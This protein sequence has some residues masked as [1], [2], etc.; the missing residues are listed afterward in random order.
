MDAEKSLEKRLKGKPGSASLIEQLD[1]KIKQAQEAV[2]ESKEKLKEEGNTEAIP[3]S[4]VDSKLF[5]DPANPDAPGII[6][7]LDQLT[8]NQLEVQ[9]I[10]STANTPEGQKERQ[11]SIDAQKTENALKQIDHN[12]PYSVLE[13]VL[14]DNT[15]PDSAKKAVADQIEK[16]EK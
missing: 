9:R 14:N 12:S 3:I 10:L 2:N 6:P 11:E 7:Q 1:N 5:G 8:V 4:P 13:N 15:L 16:M